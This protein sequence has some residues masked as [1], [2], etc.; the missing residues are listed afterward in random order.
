MLASSAHHY[1]RG[2]A[3]YAC[4]LLVILGSFGLVSRAS[5]MSAP[6]Q[7]SKTGGEGVLLHS[8]PNG[9]SARLGL[10][11]EGAS[12][13][14]SCFVWG[15]TV[16]SVPIWFKVS[17]SGLT[18]YYSSAYDNSSYQSNAE[19]TSKYGI[20]LCGQA[21]AGGSTGSSGASPLPA[22]ASS[23][24]RTAAVSWA[25]AHATAT[26]PAA[27]ACTWFVSQALWAGGLAK[28][29]AWTSSGSHG[30]VPILTRRPG[31]VD[32]WAIPNFVNYM[33]AT[34]PR[35]TY[36]EL[37]FHVNDVPLAE[38]GD[39]IVYDWEGTSSVTNTAGLDHAALVVGDAPGGHYPEVAEWGAHDAGV[40]GRAVSYKKRGWTWSVIHH[41]WLQEVSGYSHVKAFLLHINP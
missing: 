15:E 30:H 33:R 7:I 35:S 21:A 26:P 11:P 2:T 39:V 38:P 25:E 9:A 28:T 37:N 20:P 12:P 5:A 27:S 10:I 41:S 36:T 24:D 22:S 18:G 4:F 6:I 14:Y 19:L 13:D 16:N 29:A 17:Y 8:E 3:I 1:R 31:T 34:Y 23:F 40:L 32:A